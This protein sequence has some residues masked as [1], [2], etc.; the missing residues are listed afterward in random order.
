MSGRQIPEEEDFETLAGFVLAELGRLPRKGEQIE[1]NGVQFV[2]SEATDRR[3]VKVE[4]RLPTPV[5]AR[6]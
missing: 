3:V 1:R 5:E 4:L 2:V 6:P